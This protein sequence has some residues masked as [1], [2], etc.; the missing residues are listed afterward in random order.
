MLKAM[1][2][3]STASSWPVTVIVWGTFQS[4]G[5]N[6][7]IAGD[8]E[9]SAGLLLLSAN[10]TA[11]EGALVRTRSNV[12]VWP[13]SAVTSPEF[14]SS[15][16]PA[17]ALALGAGSRRPAAI[18]VIAAF[19]SRANDARRSHP[20]GGDDR[21]TTR[22][23]CERASGWGVG[24]RHSCRGVD[25]AE[26]RS[27]SNRVIPLN[28][29]ASQSLRPV[30]DRGGLNSVPSHTARWGAPGAEARAR[31]NGRSAEPAIACTAER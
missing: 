31:C 24:G 26:I 28:R 9:P 4:S 30:V 11:A 17:E 29:G 6:V 22:W 19:R 15:S 23:G 21:G 20:W 13:V 16:T 8:G 1:L 5:V 25:G 14:G 27:T 3:S 10:V 12:A 18:R 2:P 7:M